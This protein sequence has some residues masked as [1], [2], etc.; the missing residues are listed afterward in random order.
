MKKFRFRLQR[1]L[2]YR[3]LI[4]QEKLRALLI[5]NM[6]LS[7]ARGRLEA[8]L[9]AERDNRIETQRPIDAGL[10]HLSG[11]YAVRLKLEI[12]SQRIHV[13]ECEQAVEK[14]LAEYVDAAKEAEA[15]VKL[16]E[17]RLNEYREYLDKEDLK[18]IDEINTQKGN[19]F[20]EQE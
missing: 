5:C 10:V 11:L 13:Y 20:L 19:R 14:A 15:I 7:Q 9:Q 3:K 8:L 1:V 4:K 18:F 6:E 12:D 2:E 16:K 17:R